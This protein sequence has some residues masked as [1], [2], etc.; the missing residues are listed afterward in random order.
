[1]L[2][3]FTRESLCYS[4]GCMNVSYT[5]SYIHVPFCLMY[6]REIPLALRLSQ[7]ALRGMLLYAFSKLMNTI[8]K[9]FFF[10][11]INFSINLLKTWISSVVYHPSMKLNLFSL[12]TISCLIFFSITFTH[13]FIVWLRSLIPP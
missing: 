11:S 4:H 6:L 13:N 2:V 5:L 8:C 10:R 1:M 7:M 12:I 3:H 9:S